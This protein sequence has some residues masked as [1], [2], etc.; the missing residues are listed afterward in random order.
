[1]KQQ[2]YTLVLTSYI[3]EHYP[4]TIAL[5]GGDDIKHVSERAEAILL[6]VA[7]PSQH[8][9][10]DD[11]IYAIDNKTDRAVY[12]MTIRDNETGEVADPVL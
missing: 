1:M 9:W 12:V 6:A 3:D 11:A 10:V 2:R 8:E 4:Q 7:E 5:P